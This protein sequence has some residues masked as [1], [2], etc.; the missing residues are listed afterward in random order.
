[1]NPGSRMKTGAIDESGADGGSWRQEGGGAVLG[2]AGFAGK[3][4]DDAAI[5]GQQ[6]GVFEGWGAGVTWMVSVGEGDPGGV[7]ASASRWGEG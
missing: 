5:A 2:D 1:M 6:G 4:G 3:D 7:G